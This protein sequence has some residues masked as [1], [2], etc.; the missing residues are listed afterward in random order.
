MN[1][2]GLPTVSAD[3]AIEHLRKNVWTTAGTNVTLALAEGFNLF[4][5]FAAAATAGMGT[6]ALLITGGINSLAVV[7]ATCRLFLMMSCD[8]TLVLARSFKE[9]T[10]RQAGQPTERDVGAA[11]RNYRL[12]GYSQHVHT[13]IKK[14]VPRRNM[15]ASFKAELIGK[16]LDALI[17]RYKDKLS[18]RSTSL[19]FDLKSPIRRKPLTVPPVDDVDLP[20]KIGRQRIGDEDDDDEDSA[21]SIFSDLA[22]LRKKTT[23]ASSVSVAVSARSTTAELDAGNPAIP[24]VEGDQPVAELVGSQSFGGKEAGMTELDATQTYAELPGDLEKVGLG[25]GRGMGDVKKRLDYGV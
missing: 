2:F 21:S 17:L 20:L 23:N 19:P 1:C 18:K 9:V 15:A 24:E 3:V 12:R 7:P 11:A 16:E 13:D 22:N 5:I 6:G 4:G 8:L 10:F 25:G 14:L